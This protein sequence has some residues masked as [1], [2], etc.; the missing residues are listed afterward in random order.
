MRDDVVIYLRKNGK[1]TRN[2]AVIT[3]KSD[4][5]AQI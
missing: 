5:L 2:V 3:V 4:L 1:D